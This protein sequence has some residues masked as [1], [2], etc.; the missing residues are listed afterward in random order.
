VSVG[1]D[2]G[3]AAVWGRGEGGGGG[4]FS[5]VGRGRRARFVATLASLSQSRAEITSA[6]RDTGRC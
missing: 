2:S 5:S 6:H 1:E 3:E 4:E